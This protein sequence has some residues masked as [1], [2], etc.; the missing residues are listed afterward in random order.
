MQIVEKANDILKTMWDINY[1]IKVNDILHTVREKYWYSIELYEYDFPDSEWF[2]SWMT[3]K[4][5][6]KYHIILN[7][8]QAIWRYRFTAMHE[9]GHVV[10]WHL[11]SNN[12]LVN[13]AYRKSSQYTYDNRQL[14]VEANRFSAEILMPE[15]EVKKQLMLLDKIE[16]MAI[17]FWVSEQAMYVRLSVLWLLDDQS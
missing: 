6:G 9:L 3:K 14:E 5:D 13:F 10:L 12:M 17:Y 16:D 2:V 8:N 4:K 7:P 11:E 1:P 15:L